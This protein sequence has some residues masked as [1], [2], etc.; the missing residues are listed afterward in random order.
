MPGFWA[1][2]PQV[3]VAIS[4]KTRYHRNTARVWTTNDIS[5]IDA[6]SI[7]YPYCDAVFTD[8]EARA[9]MADT[10]ELRRFGTYLPQRPDELT[11]WLDD[12][13]LVADP[14]ALVPHPIGSNPKGGSIA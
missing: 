5:D 11:A 13:P 6:M 12:L 1:A 4:I 3:Q 8:R 14:S 2:M 9:A 10:R 7:A